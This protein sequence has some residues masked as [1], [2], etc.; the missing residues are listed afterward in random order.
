MN[1]GAFLHSEILKRRPIDGETF[2]AGMI[3]HDANGGMHIKFQRYFKAGGRDREMTPREVA[4]LWP[5][6]VR[7]IKADGA[8]LKAHLAEVEPSPVAGPSDDSATGNPRGRRWR[9]GCCHGG[10][11]SR[12]AHKPAQYAPMD[13]VEG[14][15]GVRADKAGNVPK[16]DL[17]ALNAPGGAL[18][19]GGM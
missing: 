3:Y 13:A 17:A 1:R 12:Y 16:V 11:R 10:S 15:G 14:R 6:L 8:A 9:E 2:A 4:A 5:D 19:R 18:T 7:A